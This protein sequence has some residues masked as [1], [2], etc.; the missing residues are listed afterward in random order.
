MNKGILPPELKSI[1]QL[2]TGDAR[3]AVPK[4]QRS[5]AWG[6]D[7]I[8]ELWEDIQSATKRGGDYFLGTLVLHRRGSA[9]Q[10]I[11]DGQQRLICVSMVFSA[12]RNVFL[13]AND[14]R[15]GKLFGEFLGAKGFARDAQ[16]HPRIVLNKINNE[17]YLQHVISSTNLKEV[18]AALRDK[19]LNDSNRALL[20]AY[21]YFLE[22]ITTEAASKGTRSDDFL[23][24]LI[25]CLGNSVKIITIPVTSEEDANLFFETL[26]ARG[27]ELAVSDLVKNRLYSESGDQ[28]MRAQQLWENMEGEL[29]RRPMS[30]IAVRHSIPTASISS[31]DNSRQWN[32]IPPA[33]ARGVPAESRTGQ[34]KDALVKLYACVIQLDSPFAFFVFRFFRTRDL[35]P[36]ITFDGSW[37]GKAFTT[38]SPNPVICF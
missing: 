26:N 25:E 12:I 36:V 10:E 13:A 17:T 23:V 33:A 20:K 8:E 21:S 37:S 18:E 34:L 27:K 1:A 2:L 5:F 38:S 14:R 30:R 19:L 32:C 28:V 11:I 15:E 29:A 24:P 6:Q 22:K 3:F 7:E 4:Y 31:Q 9:P 35:A 16:A